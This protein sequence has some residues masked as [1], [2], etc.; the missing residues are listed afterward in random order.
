MKA[1]NLTRLERRAVF[2]WMNTFGFSTNFLTLL[3]RLNA[4][5]NFDSEFT[6][7]FQ[8]FFICVGGD[9]EESVGF[10]SSFSYSCV[11]LLKTYTSSLSTCDFTS[12]SITLPFLTVTS[13][14]TLAGGQIRSLQ[15]PA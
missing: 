6:S 1:S 2:A 10:F 9:D 12:T 13:K 3:T 5:V 7:C 15:Y 8:R 4:R 14:S 11:F